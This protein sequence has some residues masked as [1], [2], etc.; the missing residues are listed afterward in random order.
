MKIRSIT[1]FVP[2]TWPLDEAT[3]VV[4]GRFLNEARSSLNEAGFEV[5]TVRLA[6]PPFLDVIGDPDTTVLLEFAACPTYSASGH[7]PITTP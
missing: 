5:Q 1:Q 4:A 2:L 7:G 6:T 3:I